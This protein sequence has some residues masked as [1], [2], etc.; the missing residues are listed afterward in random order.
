MTTT[1]LS[2]DRKKGRGRRLTALL[3]ALGMLLCLSAC[4]EAD[5]ICGRYRCTGAQAQGLDVREDRLGKNTVLVLEPDGKGTITRGDTEGA[6]LWTRSGD[7][8]RLDA[9]G[10]IF[11]ASLEG[12]TILLRMG[13]TLLRFEREDGQTRPARPET[14][15][16][17][18][19]YG[20]WSVENSQGDMP[21]VWRDCCAR[22]EPGEYGPILRFWDEESSYD[23]PLAQVQMR[24]EEGIAVSESGWFLLSDVED[25]AWTVDPAAAALELSGVCEGGGE[26]FDYRIH[27]RPWGADW[28]EETLHE[29]WRLRDWYRPLIE[30]GAAMPDR[31]G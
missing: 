2:A 29:P 20:W 12:E 28:Q 7:S 10:V 5:P 19:W 6:F 11:D 21:E 15:E 4:G 13:E 18:E 30:E 17:A 22:M 8:L 25:G 9:A 23:E 24:L 26:R 3:L 14:L 27:L 1:T 16:T 31:I